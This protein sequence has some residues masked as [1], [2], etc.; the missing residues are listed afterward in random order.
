[1]R[2]VSRECDN[3]SFFTALPSN[4]VLGA[5]MRKTQALSA[6][7]SSSSSPGSCN[8]SWLLAAHPPS[9]KPSQSLSLAL[10]P[11]FAFCQSC[12]LHLLPLQFLFWFLLWSFLLIC[13]SRSS[14]PMTTFWLHLLLFLVCLCSALIL[15]SVIIH[16]G[17]AF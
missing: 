17:Q 7:R 11:Y 13:L 12:L 9:T 2:M 1:M 8:E 4:I 5:C 15:V 6:M 3:T 16:L 10:L 14:F